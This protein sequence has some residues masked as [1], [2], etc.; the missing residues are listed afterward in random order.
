M[1]QWGVKRVFAVV[2]T[3]AVTLLFVPGARLGH[4]NS[5]DSHSL[6][7]K[8]PNAAVNTYNS[9]DAPDAVVAAATLGPA[10]PAVSVRIPCLVAC[11]YQTRLD[12]TVHQGRAPPI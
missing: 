5:Q 4:A 1:E 9:V 2:V 6:V 12:D 7:A 8:T 10:M 11:S 3:C